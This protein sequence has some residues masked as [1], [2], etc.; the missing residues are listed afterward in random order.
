MQHVIRSAA[1]GL[2]TALLATFVALLG[3]VTLAGPAHAADKDCSDFDTQQQ[4]QNFYLNNNPSLD[5]HRLDGDD[6]DGIV[7]E[8]LPCP[9]STST[10]PTGGTA[11]VLRQRGKIVKVVDG[12]TVDVRLASNNVVKRVRMIGIDTPESGRCGY[13]RATRNL[14]GLAAVGTSVTL[15]SDPSQALRDRYGRLLRYVMRNR[16]GR[17]LNKAQI[18]GGMARVYV[19]NNNPFRRTASYRD[20][21]YSARTHDR[22]LW[23][24]CW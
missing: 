10:T 6:N 4:A 21:Q 14:K 18:G 16:D 17:D 11:T 9:C 19:Y 3:T 24:T 7:C 5:P 23:A 12:D 13:V 22:G 8:S 15:V 2:V 1:L 20:A